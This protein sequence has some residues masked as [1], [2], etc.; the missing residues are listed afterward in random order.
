MKAL[1]SPAVNPFDPATTHLLMTAVAILLRNGKVSG[2]EDL[3]PM[4]VRLFLALHNGD[5]AEVR[6]FL[7]LFDTD[8]ARELALTAVAATKKGLE[9]VWPSN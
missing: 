8:E 3:L 4:L 9:K 5:R 6:R 1:A 2:V 7:S